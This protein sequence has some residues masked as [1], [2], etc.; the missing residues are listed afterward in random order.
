GSEPWVNSAGLPGPPGGASGGRILAGPRTGAT[1]PAHPGRPQAPAPAGEPGTAPP[2]G[3][4]ESALDRHRDPS[5]PRWPGGKPDRRP[6]ALAGQLSPRVS[7]RLG[8]QDLL[9]PAPAR[10]ITARERFGGNVLPA[11]FHSAYLAWCHAELGPFA[12]GSALAEE[13]LRIAEA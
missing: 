1:P 7:A 10:P 12:E 3:L 4:R 8:H 13:G 2:A 6:P 5:V 11:A 9:H